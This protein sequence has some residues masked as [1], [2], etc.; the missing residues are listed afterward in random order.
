M[1]VMDTKLARLL[2]NEREELESKINRCVEI[3]D[4]SDERFV[5]KLL[6]L[7]RQ[8][9]LAEYRRRHNLVTS[10]LRALCEFEKP[11]SL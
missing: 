6:N 7:Y 10:Q 5:T 3:L 2:L 4:C 8:N 1:A 9:R 11:Q